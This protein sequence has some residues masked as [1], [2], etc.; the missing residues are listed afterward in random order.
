MSVPISKV[1]GQINDIASQKAIIFT[2]LVFLVHDN[3]EM[4]MK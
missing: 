3:R 2:T 1:H 4:I